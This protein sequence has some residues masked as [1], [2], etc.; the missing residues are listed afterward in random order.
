MHCSPSGPQRHR[1]RAKGSSSTARPDRDAGQALPGADVSLTRE[2]APHR[3]RECITVSN[4][5]SDLASTSAVAPGIGLRQSRAR[6][7]SAVFQTILPATE[8]TTAHDAPADDTTP[9]QIEAPRVRA[10]LPPQ[11]DQCCYPIGEPRTPE[12]HYCAAPVALSGAVYCLEH[13]RLCHMRR[14]AAA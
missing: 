11:F 3:Y 8:C 13:K 9:E 6:K 10:P 1:T 5:R 2:Y 14:D 7:G 4:R 12:F